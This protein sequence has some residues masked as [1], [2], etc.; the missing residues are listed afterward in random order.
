[1]ASF[2][3]Y[4]LQIKFWIFAVLKQW[5]LQL[6][7]TDSSFVLYRLFEQIHADQELILWDAE[8]REMLSYSVL[9]AYTPPVSDC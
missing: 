4:N 8:L 6:R 7:E 9:P 5:L 3:A 1:M 2:C